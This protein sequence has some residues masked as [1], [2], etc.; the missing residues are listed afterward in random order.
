MKT[1]LLVVLCLTFLSGNTAPPQDFSPIHDG[2]TAAGWSGPTENYS[3][4]DGVIRC[5]KGKGGTIYTQKQYSDFVV[6]FE[7]QLPPGGNNG[8]AIRYPGHGD[9]AYTGM[10]ELQVLDN[11]SPK[12]AALD[13]RQYHGSAYG[14]AAA[15][16]GHLKKPGEWNQQTVTVIGSTIKVQLNGSTILDTDLSMISDYMHDTPHPGKDRTQGHFGFAGHGHA[17][18]YRNILIKELGQ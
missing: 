8:L 1:L 9:T 10:C 14:M 7:F 6:R 16:R 17:V 2:Q 13:A 4:A 11:T 18:A 3:F 15:K 5:Q 12:Y